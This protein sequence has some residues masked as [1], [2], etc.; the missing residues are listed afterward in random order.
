LSFSITFKYF[1]GLI[2]YIVNY[3]VFLVDAKFLIVPVLLLVFL[4][5]C[6]TTQQGISVTVIDVSNQPVADAL[7]QVYQFDDII[8][9]K[10]TSNLG[11][12]VFDLDVGSYEV[13][14]SH[15]NYSSS[16]GAIVDIKANEFQSIVL[17]L[18]GDTPLEEKFVSIVNGAVYPYAPNYVGAKQYVGQVNLSS[19]G[20]SV[21]SYGVSNSAEIWSDSDGGSYDLGPLYPTRAGQSLTGQD[22]KPAKFLQN[23]PKDLG[24]GFVSVE[25]LGFE[26]AQERSVIEIGRDVVSNG[27]LKFRA[28]DGSEKIVPFYL[29]VPDLNTGSTFEFDGQEFWVSTRYATSGSAT[30]Q[31][32]GTYD[33]NVVVR[34]GDYINDEKWE[35]SLLSPGS[36]VALRTGGGAVSTNHSVGEVF[37]LHGV[38]FK[39]VDVSQNS[40]I[41]AVDLAL[42]I[43]QGSDSSSVINI[44]N[45][46]GNSAN[47]SR[48]LLLL[49]NN[50]V[51]TGVIGGG[52][53]LY[54]D[55]D[56]TRPYYY[57][58]KYNDGSS[59]PHGLW[60]LLN[61]QQF[62]TQFG[63]SIYF[64][65]THISPNLLV[66]QYYPKDSD[67]G[68]VPGNYTNQYFVAE[69]SFDDRIS[70]GNQSIYI[71]TADGG[72]IGP[73]PQ[74]N[75]SNID[76]DV[77]SDT[78]PSWKL[79]SGSQSGYLKAGYTDAGTKVWLLDNDSGVKI[80]TPSG[81]EHIDIFVK[82]HTG[83]DYNFRVWLNSNP[84]Q[85][86]VNSELS[87]YELS[88]IDNGEFKESVLLEVDAKFDIS[89][90][91]K[92]LIS[93]ISSS[94]IS[95]TVAASDSIAV[96]DCAPLFGN[97]YPVV[98]V[99]PGDRTITFDVSVQCV[100]AESIKPVCGDGFCDT[101]NGETA[102]NCSLDCSNQ[103]VD[104]LGN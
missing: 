39:L 56:T 76:S 16:E 41:V 32:V 71:D 45:L 97:L 96:G 15:E 10:K 7:V 98:D 12:V 18:S 68:V 66:S 93:Q 95:Y 54:S 77:R 75:L 62:L 91:V 4:S 90:D 101:K 29:K 46:Q 37:N 19:D 24:S 80:S 94:G 104:S 22:G 78:N 53:G 49:S 85:I 30:T 88:L 89:S 87:K 13:T 67:F 82:A 55:S 9:S 63:K 60:F 72:N 2:I 59:G 81:S 74:A 57:A 58:V 100:M 28:N 48:G 47:D 31:K 102:L 35:F 69:F 44:F 99:E 38:N 33:Y 43:R 34:D 40:I 64:Q 83:D 11:T 50:S 27:G 86:E 51:F 20:K 52:V 23:A 79:T 26:G 8:A 25:F 65:G 73:F 14:A 103:P 1:C 21:V 70:N 42:D 17:R 36:F 84:G 5:G 6:A 3:G 92:D 61:G